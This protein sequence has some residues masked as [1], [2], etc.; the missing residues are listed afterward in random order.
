MKRRE[1]VRVEF[2]LSPELAE[3]VYAHAEDAGINLS[4][5]GERLI[6]QAFQQLAAKA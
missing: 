6:T 4:Q 5:A 3:R 2:S 1:R